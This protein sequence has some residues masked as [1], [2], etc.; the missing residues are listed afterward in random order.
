MKKKTPNTLRKQPCLQ[1]SEREDCF[2][3]SRQGNCAALT[4]T[5]YPCGKCPFYKPSMV[6]MRENKRTYDRLIRIERYDLVEK[7]SVSG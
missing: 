7:F 5:D 1:G 6:L 3:R 4:E 2:A